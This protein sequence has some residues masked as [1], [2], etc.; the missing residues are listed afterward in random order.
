MARVLLFDL[1]FSS[2]WLWGN[3]RGLRWVL[4]AYG[5]I[6]NLKCSQNEEQLNAFNVTP[7]FQKHWWS[8][9][10]GNSAIRFSHGTLTWSVGV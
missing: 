2:E 10:R 3:G 7:G 4:E 6:P 8:D 9:R 5:W 1:L